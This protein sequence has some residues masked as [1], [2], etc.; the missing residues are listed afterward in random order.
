MLGGGLVGWQL[1]F[2]QPLELPGTVLIRGPMDEGHAE[3][4]VVSYVLGL[5]W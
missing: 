5:A 1:I 2:M 4:L 3:P